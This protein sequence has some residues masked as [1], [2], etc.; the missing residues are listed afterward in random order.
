MQS[1][2]PADREERKDRLYLREQK[3]GLGTRGVIFKNTM[4]ELQGGRAIGRSMYVGKSFFK[5]D[6]G[7]VKIP[8]DWYLN[9]TLKVLL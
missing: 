8:D 1:Y 5:K 7:E 2:I 9:L 6:K 3:L 4:L